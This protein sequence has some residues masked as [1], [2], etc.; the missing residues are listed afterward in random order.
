MSRNPV[1][2]TEATEGEREEATLCFI[3]EVLPIQLTDVARKSGE[4]P[5]LSRLFDAISSQWRKMDHKDVQK[6]S[7]FRDELSTKSL[8]PHK[9]FLI[10]KGDTL[11]VPASLRSRLLEE[12][13]QGHMGISKMKE[14]LRPIVYWPGLSRDIAT[15]CSRCDACSRKSSPDLS[16]LSPV[17]DKEERPWQAVAVD[18]T[19]P[20]EST[21]GKILLTAIDLYSRYPFAVPISNGS[22]YCVIQELRRF[23]AMFGMPDRIISDNGTTFKSCEFEEF[24]K[25]CG[26]VHHC[27]SVYYPQANG[28][29]ERMHSTLKSRIGKMK[30]SNPDVSFERRLQKALYDMRG[31]FNESTGETPVKRFL[32]REM[33][34]LLAVHTKLIKVPARSLSER[35]AR[36]KGG[37]RE[38]EVG[39]KI[40]TRRGRG[41]GYDLFTLLFSE[42]LSACS[43]LNGHVKNRYNYYMFFC[44]Q[45]IQ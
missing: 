2:S 18:L 20:S 35:Y 4:D 8:G 7:A 16:C 15:F 3:R 24:L 34:S 9:N 45:M 33:R 32:G 11:I 14:A 1:D 19:G 41:S 38:Y 30:L 27:S 42:K 39:Q 25:L 23:F 26:I 22:S 13:H 17:A 6:Y 21:E 37:S 36:K 10:F 5:E 44:D 31:T 40:Y 29:V 28:A 12:Y 43:V